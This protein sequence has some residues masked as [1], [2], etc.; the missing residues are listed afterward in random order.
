MR[1]ISVTAAQDQPR[2][3]LTATQH[4]CPHS[5]AG[6]SGVWAGQNGSSS[7]RCAGSHGDQILEARQ[8]LL[9]AARSLSIRIC[10][11]PSGAQNR[12]GL[13]QAYESRETA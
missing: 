1:P 7:S 6:Q 8:R 3:V 10:R 4:S 12:S 13:G 9:E 11:E 5:S 2:A